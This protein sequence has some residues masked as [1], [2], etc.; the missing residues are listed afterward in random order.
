MHVITCVSNVNQYDGGPM[1][2][3]PIWQ[4]SRAVVNNCIGP[5]GA[6]RKNFPRPP[7]LEKR[8]RAPS[9]PPPCQGRRGGAF[10]APPAQNSRAF[11]RHFVCTGDRKARENPGPSNTGAGPSVVARHPESDSE[12]IR[13][14][15]SLTPVGWQERPFPVGG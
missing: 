11:R 14:R 13:E 10:S 12:H 2:W 15:Q 6:N 9:P 7:A 8:K 3:W 5:E 1:H 4:P